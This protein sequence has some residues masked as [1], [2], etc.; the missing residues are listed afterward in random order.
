MNPL[1]EWL[2]DYRDTLFYAAT[3]LICCGLLIMGA[4]RLAFDIGAV[5]L[6][7]REMARWLCWLIDPRSTIYTSIIGA[8][9]FTN[10][11]VDII[12]HFLLGNHEMWPLRAFFLMIN[13]TYIL[14]Y[15][16]TVGSFKLMYK[17]W[18]KELFD[19]PRK[20]K[21]PKQRLQKLA[22]KIKQLMEAMQPRP[23]LLPQATGF[24]PHD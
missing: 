16:Y 11:C 10:N 23:A 2:N 19:W 21:P 20:Q 3:A 8:F 5:L 24:I 13:L 6:W 14:Y 7:L 22:A 4:P 18:Y 12:V 1:L 17:I 15:L 9:V